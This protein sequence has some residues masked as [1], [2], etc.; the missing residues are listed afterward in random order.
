VADLARTHLVP[1]ARVLSDGRDP[2]DYVPALMATLVHRIEGLQGYGP[3]RPARYDAWLQAH[4][5]SLGVSHDDYRAPVFEPVPTRWTRALNV[6]GFLFPPGSTLSSERLRACPDDWLGTPREAWR[7][8]KDPIVW[9]CA[10]P[11]SEPCASPDDLPEKP[12]LP[13]GWRA[14][15][16]MESPNRYI[17]LITN[18]GPKTSAALAMPWYP[19]WWLS[20]NGRGG[21]SQRAYDF[22]Q[23]ADLL[24]GENRVELAYRPRSFIWGWIAFL[25]GLSVWIILRVRTSTCTDPNLS[26]CFALRSIA[27]WG[28]PGMLLTALAVVPVFLVTDSFA[29][30][31]GEFV[32]V[33]GVSVL[34]ALWGVSRVR[35][36]HPHPDLSAR[37]TASSKKFC[38]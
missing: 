1:S 24:P 23:R 31:M 7:L 9:P 34:W 26:D 6:T 10:W 4:N 15:R 13:A 21:Y 8:E 11:I 20:V 35:H 16:I 5:R 36:N 33:V 29:W 25:W 2:H 19:G 37:E 12:A 18:P 22:L 17:F 30:R 27:T 38:G 14:E 3:I 32:V 28:G